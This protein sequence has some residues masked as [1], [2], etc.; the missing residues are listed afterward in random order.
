LRSV[1]LV[2]RAMVRTNYYQLDEAGD[3]KP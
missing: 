1:G 3:P 2:V